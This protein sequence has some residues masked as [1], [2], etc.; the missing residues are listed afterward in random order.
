MGCKDGEKGLKIQ[1]LLES[2]ENEDFEDFKPSVVP[3][4]YS[5]AKVY[6]LQSSFAFKKTLKNL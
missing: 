6:R 1:F 5:G 4:R 3:H 2:S